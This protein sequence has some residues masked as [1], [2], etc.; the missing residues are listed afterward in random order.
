MAESGPPVPRFDLYHELEV[1]RSATT[2]TIEA[3]WRSLAKR[4]HPDEIA[5]RD[6]QTRMKRL[7][8]A[9]DWLSD[10]SLRA[11]YD[12]SRKVAGVRRTRTGA[13]PTMSHR[14]VPTSVAAAGPRAHVTI[15]SV[16]T[17]SF[18]CLLSVGIA[19]VA[20]VVAGIL[21]SA[22]NVAGIVAAIV[23]EETAITVVQLLGNLLFVALLG[24]L[25]ASSFTSSFKGRRRYRAACRRRFP[26]G[27][28]SYLRPASVL[29]LVSA[30]ACGMDGWI[31]EGPSDGSRCVA[32]RGGI[33]GRNRGHRG[34]DAHLGT[35]AGTTTG[36]SIGDRVAI[37]PPAS[38]PWARPAFRVGQNAN[39]P[40][41]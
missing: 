6:P 33:R 36:H 37:D 17:F 24:Y 41:Q 39:H 9:H 31:G 26:R 5:S 14:A 1:D 10:P 11:R 38:E 27:P 21:L 19:Y 32:D 28:R 23:G 15:A 22:T 12:A 18:W 20:S 35:R 8:I 40:A 34:V 30:C 25:V 4:F 29:R 16:A 3:A 13:S 2:E 7:N